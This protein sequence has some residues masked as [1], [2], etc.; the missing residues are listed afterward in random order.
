MIPARPSGAS[1][2]QPNARPTTRRVS[3]TQRPTPARREL[4]NSTSS[5]GGKTTKQDRERVNWAAE[6]AQHLEEQARLSRT[7]QE[8]WFADVSRERRLQEEQY[9]EALKL[10]REERERLRAEERASFL[11]AQEDQQARQRAR[12]AEAAERRRREAEEVERARR[13][14]LRECAVCLEEVDVGV[15]VE[16]P[17]THWYCRTHLRGKSSRSWGCV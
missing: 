11:R 9:N 16:V 2:P 10:A 14:R 6:Y 4:S 7:A 5:R 12:L 8:N 1:L 13:E 3:I 15:M 17:C